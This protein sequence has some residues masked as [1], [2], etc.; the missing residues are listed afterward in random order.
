MPKLLRDDADVSD[1]WTFL[2]VDEIGA[3]I[4]CAKLERARRDLFTVAIYTGLR[5]G[6]LFALQWEDVHLEGDRARLVVRRGHTG[7]T[8]SGKA[9][10]V[11]LFAPAIAALAR[12]RD[13]ALG[14]RRRVEALAGRLVF[15]GPDG[16]MYAEG[17]EAGWADKRERR[18]PEG[19]DGK[20]TLRVTLG[21]KSIAGITRDVRFHDLRHTT[22][23]HLVM[24]TWGRRW[25]LEE[26]RTFLGHSTVRVTERYA[27][28]APDALHA[29]ARE[30]AVAMLTSA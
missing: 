27:H 29:A 11:P 13:A 2:T 10:E 8:K 12:I 22:A 21:A 26:V 16:A 4:Q 15:P 20:R 7:P 28:L 3:V 9:R 30:T 17:Y 24:G 18:G 19:D 23:S 25:T 1:A 6:E 5:R 14:R